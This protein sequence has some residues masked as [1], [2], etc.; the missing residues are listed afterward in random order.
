MQAAQHITKFVL[1]SKKWD[2]A[3]RGSMQA[4]ST[5][6]YFVG[7]A[8]TYNEAYDEATTDCEEWLADRPGATLAA[9]DVKVFEELD[10][11]GLIN[12]FITIAVN[13]V[14]E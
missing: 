3:R 4:R 13:T 1:F 12:V 10:S 11:T 5:V 6:K 9:M 2:A 7:I 8:N 14:P